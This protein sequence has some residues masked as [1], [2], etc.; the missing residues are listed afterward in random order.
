M[1]TIQ[2]HGGLLTVENEGK[3]TSL[4]YLF[5]FNGRG[6]FS[7]DGKVEI[8]PELVDAHNKALSQAELDGLDNNCQIG[9]YGTF[10]YV[11]GKVTT[12]MG[13]V[14]SEIVRISGKVITFR[15]KGKVYS[16]RLQ[17]N[18]DCF[19]FRRTM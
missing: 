18:A 17:K 15:R 9:Q 6:V 8:A 3:N 13:T 14:V 12:F 19:N 2:N 7:P 16:G 11:N 1:T 5:D 10:Y 4:G